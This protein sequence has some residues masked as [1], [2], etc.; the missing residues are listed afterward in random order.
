MALRDGV[1]LAES[2]CQSPSVPS[3]VDAFDKE[4]APRCKSALKKSHIVIRMAHST[5]WWLWLAIWFLRIMNWIL[6]R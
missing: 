2:L 3:A 4:C 6:V 1:S 5:G